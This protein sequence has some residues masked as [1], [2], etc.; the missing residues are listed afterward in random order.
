MIVN[1]LLSWS[2]LRQVIFYFF[3]GLGLF[4]LIAPLTVVVPLSFNDEPYF[5]FPIVEY[6]TRWYEALVDAPAWRIATVNSVLVAAG[7]TIAATI[8]GTLAALGLS[9]PEFPAK[10]AVQ[11]L[12]ISPLMVPLIITATSLYFLYTDLGLTGSLLGLIAGH[13]TISVPFVVITVTATLVSYDTNLTRAAY[14]LGASQIYSFFRVT[15]PQILPGVISGMLFAFITS[16]DDVVIA[17]FMANAEQWTLPRQMWSGLRENIDP[18]ILA[19]ATMLTVVT[20]AL[21][22]TVGWLGRSK[23]GSDNALR[24]RR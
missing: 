12:L 3:C 8:L 24:E 14:S 15:L 19:A 1:L 2:R 7:S 22:M 9:R 4:F 21:Q 20:V 17:L 23:S 18:T 5:T 10:E 16:F 11:A 13:T 6:S